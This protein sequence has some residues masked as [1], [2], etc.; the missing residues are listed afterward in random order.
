MAP[1]NR[2]RQQPGNMRSRQQAKLNSQRAQNAPIQ[3]AGRTGP[4]RQLPPSTQGGTRVGN[5]SQPWGEGQRSGLEIRQ[6]RVNTDRPALPPARS[7]PPMNSRPQLPA[8]PTGP[9]I[10]T[11]ANN[12]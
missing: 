8:G 2:A 1:K 11:A 12:V 7:A 10:A 9:G 4:R 6:A 3:P 5:S